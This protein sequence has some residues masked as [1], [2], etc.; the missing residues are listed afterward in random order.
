MIANTLVAAKYFNTTISI[1]GCAYGKF[2]QYREKRKSI[3]GKILCIWKKKCTVD[4]STVQIFEICTAYAKFAYEYAQPASHVHWG[5]EG[6]A[7][8]FHIDLSLM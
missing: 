1:G 7:Y 4:T 5:K 8:A 6:C 2:A 3:G